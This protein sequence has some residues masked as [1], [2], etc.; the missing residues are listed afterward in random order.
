LILILGIVAV[1]LGGCGGSDST[2]RSSTASAKSPPD[3]TKEY[4]SLKGPARQFLLPRGTP[5]SVTFGR[6]ASTAEREQANGVI[7]A[8]MRARAAKDF[9]EECRY[10]SKK[11]V[12]ALVKEDAQIITRGRVT[13]CP[14]ALHYFGPMASGDFKNDLT[15]PIDSLRV[16]EGHGYALYHGRDGNDWSLGVDREAGKWWVGIAAPSKDEEE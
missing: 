9:A 14:G 2:A 6:E 5:A 12:K 7:H 8:W 13:T 3:E 1:V 11:Y 10:F 16:G 15:G 4:P